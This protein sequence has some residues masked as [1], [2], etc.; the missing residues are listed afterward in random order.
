MKSTKTEADDCS[1]ENLMAKMLNACA[2]GKYVFNPSEEGLINLRPGDKIGD[3]LSDCTI[4]PVG[5]TTC[6]H[7]ISIKFVGS[8][9]EKPLKTHE[10]IIC[11]VGVKSTDDC[12]L[13]K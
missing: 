5:N 7:Y 6:M 9:S 3:T 12:L 4:C 13:N 10:V 2:R 11:G 8:H 1:E